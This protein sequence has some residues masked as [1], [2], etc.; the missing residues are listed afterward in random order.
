M[1]QSRVCLAPIRFGAGLKGK[2]VDAMLNGTSFVTTTIG[3]EGMFGD[4]AT[5]G[6]IENNPEKYADLAVQLYENELLWKEKCLRGFQVINQRFDKTK[7]QA[8]LLKVIAE[9]MQQIDKKRLENF[10]GQMLQHHTLQSTKFMSKWI[11]E[12]NKN[13]SC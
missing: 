8:R 2:L 7:H 13:L 9:T 12:K 6:F 1:R 10:T 3:A 11:E 4:L 5:N